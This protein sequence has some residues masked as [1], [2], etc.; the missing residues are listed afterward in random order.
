ML[1]F[2]RYNSVNFQNNDNWC[3]IWSII[4]VLVFNRQVCFN[5]DK[6]N[7]IFLL[8][9]IIT[10]ARAIYNLNYQSQQPAKANY[11]LPNV[12]ILQCAM[13]SLKLMLHFIQ[14]EARRV[15]GRREGLIGREVTTGLVQTDLFYIP[16]S[17][18]WLP[19]KYDNLLFYSEDSF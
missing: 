8:F 6:T 1:T 16:P 12:L 19:P 13:L 14:G 18:T 2:R 9:N 5:N 17:S 11:K 3:K 10:K 15:G 7:M 4:W